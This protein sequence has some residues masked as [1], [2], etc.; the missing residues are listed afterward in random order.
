MLQ[1][2]TDSE[3]SEAP[4][5]QDVDDDFQIRNVGALGIVMSTPWDD[6]LGLP[7]APLT[8]ISK[9]LVGVKLRKKIN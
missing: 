6:D 1:A 5:Y 7:S 9:K 3:I 4:E 2:I 8:F